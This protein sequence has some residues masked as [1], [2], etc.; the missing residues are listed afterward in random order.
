MR[1]LLASISAMMLVLT[2]WAGLHT[3][4]A[5]A[6]DVSACSV[7]VSDT[8]LGHAPGEGDEVPSDGDK[9]TPHHHGASH[10]HD[11]GVP[12]KHS[13]PISSQHVDQPREFASGPAPG[14]FM[15]A[16]DLRPPIA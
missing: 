5:Y 13:T 16:R 1:K 11:I 7:A 6:A 10:S 14:S 4:V 15:P 9:A 2:L 3:S 8:D 12:A